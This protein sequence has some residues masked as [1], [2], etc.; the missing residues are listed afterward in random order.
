MIREGDYREIEEYRGYIVIG[1]PIN[2]I[3]RS[4][5]NSGNTQILDARS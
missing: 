1:N 3:L 4:Y 2:L 5:Y